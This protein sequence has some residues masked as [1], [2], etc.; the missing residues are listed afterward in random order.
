MENSG[1]GIWV[2]AA[3]AGILALIVAIIGAAYWLVFRKR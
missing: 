1:T 2:F 3:I